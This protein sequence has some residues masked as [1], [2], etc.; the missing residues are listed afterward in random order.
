MIARG[1]RVRNWEPIVEGT[2]KILEAAGNVASAVVLAESG[3]KAVQTRQA[4]ADIHAG[5]PETDLVSDVIKNPSTGKTKGTA[6]HKTVKTLDG[7]MVSKRTTV[8]SKEGVIVRQH[9]DFYSKQIDTRPPPGKIPYASGPRTGGVLPP[10]T[11]AGTRT[12]PKF[13][14]K[15]TFPS[16]WTGAAE[17]PGP[18]VRAPYGRT[19]TVTSHGVS[20]FHQ[21]P[22]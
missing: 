18:S 2:G 17:V 21:A 13:G 9:A 5:V 3:V 10:A 12:A 16:R 11:R 22:E 4:L 8:V 6:F 1:V 14:L 15:P 7:E 20:R 19:S